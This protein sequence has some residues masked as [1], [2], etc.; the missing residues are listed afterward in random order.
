MSGL[1]YCTIYGEEVIAVRTVGIHKDIVDAAGRPDD[2]KEVDTLIP[3]QYKLCAVFGIC[4]LLRY[5]HA[6]KPGEIFGKL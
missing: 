6:V 1:F 5:L 2:L 3:E 4:G